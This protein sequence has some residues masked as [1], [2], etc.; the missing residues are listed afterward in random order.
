M[1]IKMEKPKDQNKTD[2]RRPG[3]RILVVRISER[4][5]EV[6]IMPSLFQLSS[7]YQH[8]SFV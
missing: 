3:K 4:L 6:K 8:G 1:S 7:K 5:R 2:Y